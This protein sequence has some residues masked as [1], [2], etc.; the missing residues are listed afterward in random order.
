[1][2]KIRVL[3]ADDEPL[4]RRGVLQLLT[5]YE[6]IEVIGECCN[7]R[8][9]LQALDTLAAD[10]LFLDIQMPE[11]DGFEVLRASN[12]QRLPLIVFVTAYDA[13]AVR[14]FEMHALDYLVKP[15]NTHRFE[16][17]LTRVR[18]SLKLARDAEQTAKLAALLQEERT[19]RRVCGADHLIVAT[20]MGSR[21]ISTREIEW[22]EAE[23]YYSRIHVGGKTHLIRESLSSLQSRLNPQEFARI[24][25]SVLV[26]LSQVRELRTGDR[27]GM[28]ILYD[29]QQL[30]VS[31]RNKSAIHKLFSRS[32]QQMKQ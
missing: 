30:P 2:K 14:A 10:L 31:R 18:E 5:P 23:D 22:I 29:G 4:A 16:A 28:V 21:S 17:T 20:E 25:R 6:D 32:K 7:G 24:H 8:E 1:M 13:F 9:T 19:A 11:M 3:I 12:A 26:R 15:I 27:G